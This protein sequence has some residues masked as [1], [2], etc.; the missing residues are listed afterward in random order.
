M[1]AA[2]LFLQ[3]SPLSPRQIR[4][5]RL[6]NKFMKKFQF[7]GNSFL[8]WG[9]NG[10]MKNLIIRE[11]FFDYGIFS[12]QG[13][14][15]KSS[16]SFNEFQNSLH[17]GQVTGIRIIRDSLAGLPKINQSVAFLSPHGTLAMIRRYHFSKRESD[18]IFF[19]LHPTFPTP[20]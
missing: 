12:G 15:I 2:P 19:S 5:L 1:S 16:D 14:K 4:R 9:K 6:R 3:K 8:I 11:I 20:Q 13:R 7:L 10:K 18:L 17:S